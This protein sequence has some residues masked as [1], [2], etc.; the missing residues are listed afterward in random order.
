MDLTSAGEIGPRTISRN[1]SGIIRA[2][3]LL[4]LIDGSFR[5]MDLLRAHTSG[6]NQFEIRDSLEAVAA[7]AFLVGGY[8]TVLLKKYGRL[9]LI[10]CYCFR[11]VRLLISLWVS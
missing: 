2:I 6:F 11:I 10:A 1:W 9:V 7:F 3:G 4:G 5:V 8:G